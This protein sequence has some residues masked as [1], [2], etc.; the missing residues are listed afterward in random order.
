ME[1]QKGQLVFKYGNSMTLRK[2]SG[3]MA[4]IVNHF[5][6]YWMLYIFALGTLGVLIL[7]IQLDVDIDFERWRLPAF[8]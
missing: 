7:L 5:R 2:I 3:V 8:P 4:W 1:L 6:N